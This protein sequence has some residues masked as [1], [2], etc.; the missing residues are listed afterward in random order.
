MKAISTTGVE[1]S[2]ETLTLADPKTDN[3]QSNTWEISQPGKREHQI[4][5]SKRGNWTA[6][7]TNG[8]K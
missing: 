2:I 3:V 1:S 8:Q 4:Y 7:Y 5:Y 6:E